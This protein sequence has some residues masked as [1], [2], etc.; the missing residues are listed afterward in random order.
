METVWTE[1]N[2]CGVKHSGSLLCFQVLPVQT[3]LLLARGQDAIWLPLRWKGNIIC[4]KGERQAEKSAVE[5][6]LNPSVSRT[7]YLSTPARLHGNTLF[8]LRSSDPERLSRTDQWG[9]VIRKKWHLKGFCSK[10]K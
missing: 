10:F 1:I 3:D 6:V 7:Y 8:H 2:M 5:K 9:F 4:S